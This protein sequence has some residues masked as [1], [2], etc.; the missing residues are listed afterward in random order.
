MES[1]RVFRF[2]RNTVLSGQPLGRPLW[3]PPDLITTRWLRFE[4]WALNDYADYVRFETRI[5]GVF[6]AS[7]ATTRVQGDHESMATTSPGRPRGSPLR[8]P[9]SNIGA[10]SDVRVCS[11]IHGRRGDSRRRFRFQRTLGGIS[12]ITKKGNPGLGFP[13]FC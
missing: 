10:N 3:S 9:Y 2:F 5:R 6:H 11:R 13:F 4:R 8:F 12:P 7:R 1:G